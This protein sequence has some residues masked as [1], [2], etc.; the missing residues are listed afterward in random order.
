MCKELFVS[1]PYQT[2][3]YPS[4]GTQNF[5]EHFNISINLT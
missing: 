5:H 4:E 1:S 2:L 3:R